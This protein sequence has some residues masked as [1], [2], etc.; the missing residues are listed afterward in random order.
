MAPLPLYRIM[1][2]NPWRVVSLDLF[3]PLTI[4][5]AVKKRTTA[6]V[7]GVLFNCAS[8]RSVHLDTTESYSCDSILQTIQRFTSLRG[9]PEK[10]I[11]DQG[12]Q[13]TAAAGGISEPDQVIGHVQDEKNWSVVKQWTRKQRTEWDLFQEK[14]LT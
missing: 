11:S 5:D 3:G 2:S 1:I 10:F 14:H 13:L 8:T 6:K 4:R 12:S 9:K 7:W